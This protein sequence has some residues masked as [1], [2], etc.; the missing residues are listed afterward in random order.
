MVFARLDTHRRLRRG[1]PEA[2]LCEGKTAAHLVAITRRMMRA[3]ELIL[4]T[5]LEP[6]VAQRLREALPAL[7]YDA[8]ARLGFWVPRRAPKRAVGLVVVASGGT[9][10][11]PVAEEAAL[12]LELL[13]SRTVRLYDVGVA[14]IHRV[15]S[16]F[17]LLQ[18]SRAIVVAAGME[19]A[20][21]SVV[22]GL[23][24][25]PVVAVPTS[26]GYGASFS[27]LGALLTMLNSCAPGVA[28][29][30]I[31][32]GFGAGYLAHVINQRP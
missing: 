3:K 30:N 8:T 20:L 25:C 19:G 23:A 28:V 24:R 4:L 2:V 31:D 32:N 7:R 17:A 26:V 10:D 6:S 21:A 29:V 16:A 12:T 9:A 13:G 15:L 1:V 14:G 18:R 22:A 11:I 5:R 27:G